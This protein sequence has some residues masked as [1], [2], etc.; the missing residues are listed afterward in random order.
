M[1]SIHVK[2]PNQYIEQITGGI[3]KITDCKNYTRKNEKVGRKNQ[4]RENKTITREAH[5]MLF[6]NVYL[7]K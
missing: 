1:N 5:C 4:I 6:F 3:R 2:N 7:Y